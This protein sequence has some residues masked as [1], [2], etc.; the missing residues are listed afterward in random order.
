MHERDHECRL[1]DASH[2]QH[3]HH[4]AALLHH[5]LLQLQALGLSPV[6]IVHIKGIVPI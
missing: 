4:L 3:T 2:P 5:P 1:A 6:K